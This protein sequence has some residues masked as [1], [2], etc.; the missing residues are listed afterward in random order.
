MLLLSVGL[1]GPGRICAQD[2]TIGVQVRVSPGPLPVDQ[3]LEISVVLTGADLIS[4]SAFPALAGFKRTTRSRQTTTRTVGTVTATTLTIT[5]RYL[6]F[7]EGEK[8][9]PPFSIDVN[10][11]PV[12]Y[13]GG[14]VRVVAAS[15]LAPVADVKPGRS[16]GTE[17]PNT[18]GPAP[19]DAKPTPPDYRTVPDQARLTLDV[20]P[21]ERTVWAGEGVRVRLYLTIAPEDQA[22][23]EFAPDFGRQMELIRRQ[24]KPADV[25]EET[26]PALPIVPDTVRP[27]P[28][29]VRLRFLLHEAVYYPLTATQPLRF[30]AIA[31]R[32]TKY[33]LAKKTVEGQDNRLAGARTVSS[34]PVTVAV[35]PLPP[36]PLRDAV[37]V[38]S[39]QLREFLSRDPA[40]AGQPVRYWLEISGPGNLATVRFPDPLTTGPTGVTAYRPQVVPTP[41]WPPAGPGATGGSVRFQWELVADRAGTHRLDS[42][43]QLVYFDPARGRY[44]TLRSGLHW[45][46]TGVPRTTTARPDAPPWADDPFYQ[47]IDRESLETST[48]PRPADLRRSANL[49]LALL[50]AAGGWLLWR[51]RKRI[52]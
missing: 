4:L 21:A 5:Q 2:A 16:A 50:A 29:Q 6:A 38:G 10:G 33:A 31:L 7:G 18:D 28:D 27:A 9:L 43:L 15:T 36:H 42:L 1:F 39:F 12:R 20:A 19:P 24:V 52:E 34:E 44:D 26:P 46:V 37:P 47:R 41:A 48:A 13:P 49:V 32:L 8:V 45:R 14:R 51:R 23:L 3:P 40:R 11:Q 25:W 17:P 30:P 35:R 22:V